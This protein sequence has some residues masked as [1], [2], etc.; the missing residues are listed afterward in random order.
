MDLYDI[1]SLFRMST[2]DGEIYNLFEQTFSLRRLP[3][4]EY[5]VR[6]EEEMRID[7]ISF[8]IYKTTDY[9]DLILNLN[10]IDNPLNIKYGDVLYY[11]PYGEIE[12][13]R[14][15]S[16][17]KIENRKQLLSMD[18]SN[19]KDSNR[20]K[21]IEGDYQLP[22]NILDVPRSPILIGKNSITITPLT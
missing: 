12:D 8:S 10:D 2:E 16:T 4:Y 21:F 15:K 7:L 5:I 3:N 11:V 1:N 20:E 9:A 22:P 14:I 18:K 17:Q 19:I 6:R 13:F